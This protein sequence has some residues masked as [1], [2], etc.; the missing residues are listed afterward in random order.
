VSHFPK[1]E[2]KSALSRR[3]FL[4]Y[5]TALTV[6]TAL[7]STGWAAD[8][9]KGNPRICLTP[10]SIG[11]KANQE[12]AIAL[13]AQHRYE[14]VEPYGEQLA[15][16]SD[17]EFQMVLAHL[18]EKGLVW[19]AAGLPMEFRRE[20]EKFKTGLDSL[21]RVAAALQKAGVTRMG[22][23][24]SPGHTSLTYLQNFKQHTERLRAIAM[25]LKD[26][27]LRLGLEYVGTIT[28]RQRSRYTFI[29]TM[30]EMF[31]LIS[32]IGT[33]NVGLVLDSW[34]WWQAGDT[35]EDIAKLRGEQIISVDLNDAPL[36]LPRE[37]Q[38]DGKRELPAATGVI[39]HAGF[40]KALV[41]I[42]YSGPVRPEPFNKALNDLENE[43]ACAAASAALH[44]AFAVIRS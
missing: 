2:S 20:E 28:S 38:L 6:L 26:H 36:N 18:N 29:H 22:T 1:N 15:H 41:Q 30:A 19:G 34:H 3:A 12:E 23:W 8:G 11:V 7:P 4:K 42:G 9:T 35:V 10:G 32:A 24:L 37:Q 39:D 43:P 31:E 21:P 25:V 16:A 33:G 14:A 13:A 44:K 5:S 27:D 40:L 17:E